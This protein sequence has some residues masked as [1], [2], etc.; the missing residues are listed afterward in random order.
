MVRV[1]VSS[2][3]EYIT[4]HVTCSNSHVHMQSHDTSTDCNGL[5]FFE[6]IKIKTSIYVSFTL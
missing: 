3:I 6:A 5:H 4:T 1:F 2:K